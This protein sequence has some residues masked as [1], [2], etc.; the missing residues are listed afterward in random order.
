MHNLRVGTSEA[1]L[2]Y[3]IVKALICKKPNNYRPLT[4][5]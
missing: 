1:E 5:D 3:M 2:S 4:S